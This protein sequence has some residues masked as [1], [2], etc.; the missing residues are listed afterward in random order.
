[1]TISNSNLSNFSSA[2]VTEWA[3]FGLI[4]GGTRSS[5]NG[6]PNLLFMYNDTVTNMP[7]GVNVTG[8][9]GPNTNFPDPTELLLLNNTFYNDAIGVNIISPNFDNTNSRSLVHFVAMDNIFSNSTTTAVQD[10][11]QVQGSELEYNLFFSNGATITD[12]GSGQGS[13]LGGVNFQPIFG[14]PK[15]RNAAERQL[16]A[17]RGVRGDRRRPRRA[18]P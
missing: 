15:F 16:P 11:G 10:A 18:E 1:M 13:G 5:F 3:G 2:G 12:L 6:E 7:I 9:T 14:D 8:Q 4:A 17:H